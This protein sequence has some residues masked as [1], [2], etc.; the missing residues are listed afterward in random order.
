[1]K[2]IYLYGRLFI[3][4]AFAASISAQSGGTF[5]I[6][7]SVIANGGGQ[8][9]SGTFT[10]TGTTGQTLAG[11]LSTGDTFNVRGG[12]WQPPSSSNVSVS[13]RVL[14]F[15]GRGVRNATVNL[16][17]QLNIT[18]QVLIGPFGAYRFDNVVPGQSYTVSVTSRRFQFTLRTISVNDDLTGV[19][20]IASP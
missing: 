15:G 5:T 3:L 7:Q 8:S 11:T 19:N 20:F 10:V 4:V 18:R 13:G 14:T 9:G 1:M 2:K 6:T 16:T 12:F 17:N